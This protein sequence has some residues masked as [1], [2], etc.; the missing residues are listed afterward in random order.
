MI[1]IHLLSFTFMTLGVCVKNFKQMA[2]DVY[3]A[4]KNKD[5]RRM[6]KL[7]DE[8]MINASASSS[9]TYLKLSIFSYVL[10]KI[11]SKP[12]F[13]EKSYS[14]KLDLIE[15]HLKTLFSIDE[16]DPRSDVTFAKLEFAIVDLEKKDKRF[17][18]DLISKG[19]LKMAA[20][21]YAQGFSLS[22]ASTKVGLEKQE[23]LSYAG[24]T[25]MFD[26]INEEL[27]IMDRVKIARKFIS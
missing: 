9:P 2:N 15:S 27:G 17:V 4:F 21:I 13:L 6:R 5:Q 7:N 26:R 19:K 12:R 22:V 18:T 11:L 8:I 24:E 25:M 23:I 3:E 1:M 16:F 20:T 14:S 10:S